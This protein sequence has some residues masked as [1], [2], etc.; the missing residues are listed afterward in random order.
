[1]KLFLA[2]IL[3]LSSFY[4]SAQI[5]FL[6]K[7]NDKAQN[8]I[9][10]KLSVSE[11]D[12]KKGL[13]EALS[14]G[15]EYAIKEASAIN[16]FNGNSLI[17][18]PFPQEA[19]KMKEALVRIGLE[20][21]I[22]SMEKSI[23]QSAEIA[24][25]EALTILISAIKNMNIKDAY[26]ILK[27]ED[28]AATLYLNDQTNDFL[29]K[30]FKPIIIESMEKVEIAKQWNPLVKKYN[31]IPFTEKINPDLE[32]YITNKAIEG[33]FVLIAQQEKEIRQNPLARTTEILKNVFKD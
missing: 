2:T 19:K 29:Y 15:S 21:Q 20:E 7:A 17:R 23:N 26:S 25:K 5:G 28:N 10:S 12:V 31:S 24:S 32:D 3:L 6:K 9:S 4:A 27:G 1:M 22:K 8:L 13:V 14:K 18:I 30:S 11:Q 33:L 16:G